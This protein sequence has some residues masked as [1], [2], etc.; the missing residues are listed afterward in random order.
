MVGKKTK[1]TKSEE[2]QATPQ[3]RSM[4]YLGGRSKIAGSTQSDTSECTNKGNCDVSMPGP[5][6]ENINHLRLTKRHDKD[7]MRKEMTAK[8]DTYLRQNQRCC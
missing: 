7:T 6:I 8:S 4:E 5:Y 3:K 1:E 2:A